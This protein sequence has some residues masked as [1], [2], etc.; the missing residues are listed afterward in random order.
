V[1]QPENG[2]L[3]TFQHPEHGAEHGVHEPERYRRM[4][5]RRLRV[6]DGNELRYELAEQEMQER[7]EA[8]AQDAHDDTPRGS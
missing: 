2:V 6:L 3:R 4:K 8:E 5:R 1:N 7:E